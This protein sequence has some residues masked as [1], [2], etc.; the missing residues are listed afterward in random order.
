M[1]FTAYLQP[2]ERAYGVLSKVKLNWEKRLLG[3]PP[4]RGK[5][6]QKKLSVLKKVMHL[7]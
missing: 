4:E 2:L 6:V 3:K 5:K 7:T 1:V